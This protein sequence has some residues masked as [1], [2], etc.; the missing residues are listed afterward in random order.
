MFSHI[1]KKVDLT[2]ISKF[3]GLNY[4]FP[5]DQIETLTYDFTTV[6]YRS[7]TCELIRYLEIA[8]ATILL[9]TNRQVSTCF[10]QILQEFS[11]SYLI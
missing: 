7:A 5:M 8:L 4:L 6:A 10:L 3:N 2:V 9:S 1:L 11:D